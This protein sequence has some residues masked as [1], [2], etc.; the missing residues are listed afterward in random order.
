[1]PDR[2]RPPAPGAAAM[3]PP[4]DRH[5]LELPPFS[6]R[7]YGWFMWYVRRYFRRHF[8]ALRLLQDGAGRAV[9]PDIAGEPAIFY[10]N[11]PGWWDPLTFLL[12]ADRLYP[13]RLNYGPIDARALGKYRFMERIGFLGIEPDT[14]RGAARFLKAARAASRR[15]D[16]IFWITSQGEFA[17]PRMRP[18]GIRPGVAH[19]AAAAERGLIVPVAVEYPFWS[20]RLPEALVAFGPALR[21]ADASRR[22]AKE[23]TAVLETALADTQDRLARAAIRRDPGAFTVLAS[24]SVGVGWIYDGLRRL[25]AWRRGERFDASHGGERLG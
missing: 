7:L 17:D 13:D 22:D 20:E 4:D 21:I 1:M 3:P 2:D 8:H 9:P 14:R 10:A 11:H 6:R 15:T 24:G 23:W 19:A 5:D 18:P 12:L 25:G 16:V